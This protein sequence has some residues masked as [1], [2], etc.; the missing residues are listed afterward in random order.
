MDIMILVTLLEI[1]V[2]QYGEAQSGFTI[3]RLDEHKE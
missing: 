2:K 1:K 3:F